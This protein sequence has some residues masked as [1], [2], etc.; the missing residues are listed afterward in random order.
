MWPDRF[1]G[2]IDGSARDETDQY[3]TGNHG[4]E[5]VRPLLKEHSERGEKTGVPFE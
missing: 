4:M 1:A 2:A 3:R 5:E